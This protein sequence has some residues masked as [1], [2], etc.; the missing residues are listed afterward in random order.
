MV[1]Y[2]DGSVLA[3]LGEPDMR[4]AIGYALSHPRRASLPVGRL[5]FARLKTLDFEDPGRNPLSGPAAGAAGHAA[6]RGAGR[7]AERRQ[8]SC[9]GSLH[10]R[11]DRL[12]E[13][14]RCC[15]NGHGPDAGLSTCQNDGGC[16]CG[17]PG[18]KASG[19]VLPV[20]CDRATSVRSDGRPS[21]SFSGA[22][23][24]PRPESERSGIMRI[25]ADMHTCN[26]VPIACRAKVCSGFAK[27]TRI[28]KKIKP[29][30]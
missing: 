2:T 6:R 27:K 8:G 16:V 1:G 7:S 4:T 17:R 28:N 21:L 23:P 9:T 13:H 5:D 12:F 10:C 22:K 18:G 14:G 30:A 24:F 20:G 11:T 19:S 15:R 3:Q 25:A 26:A 29:V